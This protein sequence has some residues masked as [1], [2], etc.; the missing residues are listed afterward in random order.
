MEPVSSLSSILL[1]E[2]HGSAYSQCEMSWAKVVL[3]GQLCLN[4]WEENEWL[5]VLLGWLE[6]G[7]TVWTRRGGVVFREMCIFLHVCIWS[8][9]M[10]TANNMWRA[11]HLC[12]SFL[13]IS[14]TLSTLAVQWKQHI[15]STTAKGLQVLSDSTG[16][17][18]PQDAF[19]KAHE[20]IHNHAL[21][22]IGDKK[23]WTLACMYS[24]NDVDS[25][26]G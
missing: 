24:A 26:I 12:L 15:S 21:V 23:E 13:G 16:S 6:I 8:E 1:D 5:G 3:L 17:V 11:P 22:C 20:P 7:N 18:Q 10:I 19:D 14:Y 2:L 25:C 4:Q 9:H